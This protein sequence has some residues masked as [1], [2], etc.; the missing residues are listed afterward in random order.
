MSTPPY[1]HPAPPGDGHYGPPNAG[2]GVQEHRRRGFFRRHWVLTSLVCVVL[3]VV[4]SAGVYA[5]YLNSKLSNV[6]TYASQL[7]STDRVPRYAEPGSTADPIGD[8]QAVNLLLLGADNGANTSI[9]DQL[10]RGTWQKGSMRSDTIMFVHIPAD[11]SHAY[12]V[13]IPRDSWVDIPGYG[14]NK[15]NAAFSFGGPDLAVRTVEQLTQVHIDH[16]VM[17]DWDGFRDLTTALGG[18]EITI[19]GDGAQKLSGQEALD[20]VRTR[21]TL[22]HGDFD[23]IKRQQ[24]FIRQTV[25]QTLESMSIT[26]IGMLSDLLGVF[27]DN[28]TVDAQL[29]PSRMRSLAWQLKGLRSSGMTFMTAPNDG[30]G[31]VGKASVVLLNDAKFAELFTAVR[32]QQMPAYLKTHDIDGLPDS[33]HVR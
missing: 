5:L 16:V 31:M 27:G 11:R 26:N 23:R 18:V 33:D 17:I 10:A 7:D 12:V 14:K 20:Y 4:G 6:D 13:S 1:G 25:K 15:V 8:S 2:P 24:N 32:T 22:P 9:A 29:T 28:T 19:P 3:L 30:S 21:K